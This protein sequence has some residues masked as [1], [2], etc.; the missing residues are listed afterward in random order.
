[1]PKL[2]KYTSR[3]SMASGDCADQDRLFYSHIYSWVNLFRHVSNHLM[4]V[5]AEMLCTVRQQYILLTFLLKIFLVSVKILSYSVLPVS[6]GVRP[7][8]KVS[9][10]QLSGGFVVVVVFLSVWGTPS[11]A[12]RGRF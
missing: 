2:H 7:L 6:F 9:F 10:P 12:A 11:A 4:G 3:Q 8:V 1:M 5:H